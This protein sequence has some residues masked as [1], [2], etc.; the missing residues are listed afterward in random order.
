MSQPLYESKIDIPANARTALVGVLNA[1]LADAID[2]ASQMKQAH[3]NVKGPGFF[4]LH[5]L[6]DEV[7][8]HAGDWADGLAERAVQLGGVADGRAQTV[9]KASTLPAIGLEVSEG[10]HLVEALAT[11]VARF[12]AG[13]RAAIDTA[14]VA[15]DAATSDL[16]T[17][18]VRGADKDLWM[19]E[20]HLEG[21]R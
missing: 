4:S 5:G 6:F 19:L 17:E 3:W 18:I 12:S 15:G 1:R 10:L 13:A 9:T 2:L 16:F 8:G 7:Y 11:A 20:A 14:A 21:R